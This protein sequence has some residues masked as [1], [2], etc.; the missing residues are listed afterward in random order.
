MSQTSAL[1]PETTRQRSSIARI[2]GA[3][4]VGTTVEWYDFFLYGVAAAAVF[5][6]VFFPSNDEAALVMSFATF[7]FAYVARPVGAVILARRQV[8]ID[9]LWGTLRPTVRGALDTTLIEMI[10]VLRDDQKAKMRGMIAELHP[11]VLHH[12]R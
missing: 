8:V 11:G 5:P 1:E 6:H 7:G 3:S 2:V 10:A 4:L 9:S 12:L